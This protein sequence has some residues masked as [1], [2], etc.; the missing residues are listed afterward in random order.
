LV[1]NFVFS[2]TLTSAAPL[3]LACNLSTGMSL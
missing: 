2:I 3:K 1:C